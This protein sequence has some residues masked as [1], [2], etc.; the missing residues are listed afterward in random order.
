MG[1]SGRVLTNHTDTIEAI[2]FANSFLLASAAADGWLCLWHKA[3]QLSQIF[4]GAPN[5]FSRLAWHPQ[6][7]HIAAGGQDGELLLWSK[8]TRGQGFSRP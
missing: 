1:R 3:K 7:N 8:G 5:G 4:K 6:G 2:A